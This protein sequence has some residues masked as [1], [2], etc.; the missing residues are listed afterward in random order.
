MLHGTESI[1]CSPSSMKAS[2]KEAADDLR[3]LARQGKEISLVG[4]FALEIDQILAELAA[5]E[6]SHQ[7]VWDE[8]SDSSGS[9]PADRCMRPTQLVL[10]RLTIERLMNSAIKS[11]L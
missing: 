11:A 9:S 6:H 8:N 3:D 10:S 4:N 1:D 7:I 5:V 2:Y